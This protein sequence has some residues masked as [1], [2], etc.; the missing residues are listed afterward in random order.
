MEYRVGAEKRLL[1]GTSTILYRRQYSS[2]K[3]IEPKFWRYKWVLQARP[4]EK[5]LQKQKR[6]ESSRRTGKAQFRK[7]Q[8]TIIY[9]KQMFG[10]KMH[11]TAGNLYI[12]GTHITYFFRE[13]FF[14]TPFWSVA[15]YSQNEHYK[16]PKWNDRLGS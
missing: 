14:R 2:K 7:R 11:L 15:L 10:I 8:S 9:H 12:S 16:S 6:R 13:F 1:S 3:K 5:H 4:G